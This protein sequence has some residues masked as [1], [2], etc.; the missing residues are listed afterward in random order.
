MFNVFQMLRIRIP[1]MGGGGFGSEKKWKKRRKWGQ[2]NSDIFV[3]H[4]TFSAWM[5]DCG[6]EGMKDWG[7][8]GMRIKE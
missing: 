1:M 6:N 2:K 5:N 3:K 8:E 4:L 7:H